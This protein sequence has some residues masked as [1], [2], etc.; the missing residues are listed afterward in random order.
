MRE[1]M[2]DGRADAGADGGRR[3]GGT[4]REGNDER[5]GGAGGEADDD[6]ERAR[7]TV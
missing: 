1:R 4:A 6:G 3:E 5:A 2:R 7:A